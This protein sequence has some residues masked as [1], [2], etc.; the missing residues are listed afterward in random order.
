MIQFVD[1]SGALMLM[2]K[3]KVEEEDQMK[4]FGYPSNHNCPLHA[5]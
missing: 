4:Y 5:G 2:K 3:V 1:T